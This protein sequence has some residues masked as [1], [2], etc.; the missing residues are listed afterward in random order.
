MKLLYWGSLRWFW[1]TLEAAAF[2]YPFLAEFEFFK[3]V[4]KA[5]LGCCVDHLVRAQFLGTAS[6]VNYLGSASPLIVGLASVCVRECAVLH[7][8]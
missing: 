4:A 1:L 3:V 6:A 5:S 7:Q 8:Q 2:G